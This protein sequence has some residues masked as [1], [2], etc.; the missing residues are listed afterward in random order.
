MVRLASVNLPGDE[1]RD[2]HLRT[3]D[4][5]DIENHPTMT[6]RSSSVEPEA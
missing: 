5:F 1:T 2:K 6:F 4:F 3:N